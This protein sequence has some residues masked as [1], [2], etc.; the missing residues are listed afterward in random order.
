MHSINI[1]TV[2]VEFGQNSMHSINIFTQNARY[3]VT[4]RGSDVSLLFLNVTQRRVV[5]TDVSGQPV[6]SISMVKL[7]N[8]S[9]R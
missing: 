5:V 4:S 8:N 1:F 7:S 9:L 6:G 2:L 3:F